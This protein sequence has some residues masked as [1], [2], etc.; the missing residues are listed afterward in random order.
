MPAVVSGEGCSVVVH[1]GHILNDRCGAEAA[2]FKGRSIH[3][4]RLLRGARLQLR[5]GGL[6][7]GE[8][9]RLLSHTAGQCHHITGPVVDDHNGRLEL[10]GGAGGGDILQIG[11]NGI[12]L[13]LHVHIQGGI[14]MVAA[15]LDALQVVVPGLLSGALPIYAILGRQ[16][17]GHVQNGRI[18]KPGIYILRGVLVD[19][20][21]AAAIGAVIVAALLVE[22]TDRARIAAALADSPAVRRVDTLLKDHLLIDGLIILLLGQVALG[23]HFREHIQLAIAVPARAVPHLALVLE[24]IFGIGIEQGR[25]IGNADEAGALCRGQALQLLAEVGSS[26][27][28]HA[29]ATLAQIDAVQVL[30]HNE[31]LIVFL[32]KHLGPENLHDLSLHRNAVLL[33]D[34]FDQLLGNGGAAELGVSAEEHIHA[35]LDR[36]NPVH[37]L[38]LIEALILN[39]HRSIDQVL[40]DLI[41]SGNLPVRGGINLLQ[42]LNIAVA[43][44]IIKEGGLFQIVVINGPIRSFLQDIVLQIIPQGAHKDHAADQQNQR[45]RQRRANGDLHHRQC[46]AAQGIEGLQRP[47]GIPLLPQ[48]LSPFL[49][50]IFI[51]HA[52]NLQCRSG[53][54]VPFC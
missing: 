5:L 53:R 41:Q 11:I 1:Q 46:R 33:A 6:V 20:G 39:G 34:V 2:L 32:F 54:I 7:V 29:V 43:I 49:F 50:G 25:V 51:C 10:L 31:V 28:L 38:V 52:Y 35:G 19:R 16:I 8:E 26:R 12:H 14:D 45:N 36:G 22:G 13:V 18:H 24:D 17:G 42:L 30:I 9:V 23:E 15:L 40:R 48:L 37:A 21:Q 47:V 27:A 3:G 4:N 44:H